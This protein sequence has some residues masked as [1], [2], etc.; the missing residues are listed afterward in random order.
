MASSANRADRET[1]KRSVM[2]GAKADIL[3]KT[4]FRCVSVLMMI[5]PPNFSNSAYYRILREGVQEKS[6]KKRL[7]QTRR[8]LRVQPIESR[9]TTK[10]EERPATCDIRLAGWQDSR[11]GERCRLPFQWQRWRSVIPCLPAGRR[12][13]V[14]CPSSEGCGDARLA[15]YGEAG[16][17]TRWKCRH[18][19]GC[20][21][22]FS[23]QSDDRIG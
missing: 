18:E 5:L 22:R 19:C 11:N 23:A 9:S 12:S 10:H 4:L 1:T 17:A 15:T 14:A 21:S 13:R 6:G 2:A 8:P 16:V 20:P 7:L 3:S